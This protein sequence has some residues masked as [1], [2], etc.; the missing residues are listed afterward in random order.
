MAGIGKIKTAMV[1]A[2]GRGTRMRAPAEAPPKPLTLLA[3]RTLLDR[4]IDKLVGCGVQRIIVNVHFKAGWIEAHLNQGQRDDLEIVISDER[5]ALLETG[6]GVLYAK[7]LLGHE[8][9]F[10]CNSDIF[11]REE[12]DNLLALGEYFDASRMAACLLMADR[13]TASGFDGAGDFFMADDG[14]LRRRTDIV[15]ASEAPW[16]YAGAQIVRPDLLDKA[17]AE[18]MAFSF[19]ML[20]DAALAAGQLYG[21]ALQGEWM[22]IGTPAGL[23]TAERRLAKD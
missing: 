6:G 11:W 10:V 9:F 2:A 18:Q 3:G 15:D 17:P 16:V 12:Q 21:S 19:N 14:A 1:L 8:P 20:W 7:P 13:T 4:M 22:H 23:A 5:D